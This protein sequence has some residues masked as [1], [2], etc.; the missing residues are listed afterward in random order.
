MAEISETQTHVFCF[1]FPERCPTEI[2]F[3]FGLSHSAAP[4][5]KDFLPVF[6]CLPLCVCVWVS[7]FVSR[8]VRGLLRS[9]RATLA[10]CHISCLWA[11][12]FLFYYSGQLRLQ[13][14]SST[15]WFCI[16]LS[17]HWTG[18]C[19]HSCALNATFASSLHLH[20]QALCLFLCYGK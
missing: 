17:I 12:Y 14:S 20:S 5:R 8:R 7:V 2:L 13:L 19:S 9:V 4:W 10:W 3:N 18:P 1:F 11:F 16:S 6:L 15:Q